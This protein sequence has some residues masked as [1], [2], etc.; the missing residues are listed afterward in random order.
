MKK[1][2]FFALV[3]ILFVLIALVLGTISAYSRSGERSVVSR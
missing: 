2:K 1:K 3:S